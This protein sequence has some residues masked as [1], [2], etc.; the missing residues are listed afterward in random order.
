MVGLLI[1]LVFTVVFLFSLLALA[2]LALGGFFA[3]GRRL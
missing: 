2:V 3:P 1:I